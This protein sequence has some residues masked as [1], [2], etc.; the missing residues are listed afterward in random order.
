MD[1]KEIKAQVTEQL[2]N[3]KY[4]LKTDDGEEII[5]YAGGRLKKNKI[6]LIVGDEVKVELDPYGGK[7]T[8]RITWRLT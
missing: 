2:P 7:G 4:R 6:R 3:R 1:K 5:G 8:N